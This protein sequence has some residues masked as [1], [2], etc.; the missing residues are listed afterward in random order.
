M[1]WF[2]DDDKLLETYQ[3]ISTKVDDW[4][5]NELDA[6]PVYDDSQNKHIRR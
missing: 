2:T 1:S 3:T 4:K 6:L 5:N